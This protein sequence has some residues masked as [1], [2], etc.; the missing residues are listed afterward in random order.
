MLYYV[1]IVQV[2]RIQRSER[3]LRSSQSASWRTLS[4]N[5]LLLQANTRNDG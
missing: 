1:A 4:M 2:L 5:F 3:A